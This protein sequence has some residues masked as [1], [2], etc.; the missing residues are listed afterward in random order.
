MNIEVRAETLEE[1]D[2]RVTSRLAL[3]A[4]DRSGPELS[5]DRFLW[6]YRHGYER[7]IIISAFSDGTKIGQ[8]VCFSKKVLLAGRFLKAAELVDLFVSPEFRGFK[9]ASSL[10]AKMRETLEREGTEIVYAYANERA[11]YMNRRYLSMEEATPL[12]AY[13]G[14]HF[15]FPVF[16]R[17][18]ITIHKDLDQI[19]ETCTSHTRP[20]SRAGLIITREQLVRRL[21]SPMYNYL[22]ASNGE[23][24]I[25]GSP[26]I[27]RSVPVLLVCATFTN[28]QLPPNKK[29]IRALTGALCRAAERR[30]FFYAGWNDAFNFKHGA[31]IPDSLLKGKLLIQSNW[32]N[33]RRQDFDRFELIDI[34]YA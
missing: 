31:R 30:I 34:D 18:G 24:A 4:F 10:Y 11:S 27:I 16:N 9:V 13:A 23:V 2:G 7:V 26:R 20:T 33:S 15:N 5:S 17:S 1:F 32:M 19:A 6:A 12:P 8:L 14:V 29:T 25:I 22:S 21:S 28:L 3:Q